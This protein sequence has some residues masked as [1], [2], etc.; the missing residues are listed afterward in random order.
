MILY[1]QS[2]LLFAEEYYRKDAA[3]P[4]L[5]WSVS[6]GQNRLLEETFAGC[7][8]PWDP[9][10]KALKSIQDGV[11]DPTVYALAD[12]PDELPLYELDLELGIAEALQPIAP[13][14]EDVEMLCNDAVADAVG[15]KLEE[16]HCNGDGT[17]YDEA[18]EAELVQEV[19]DQMKHEPALSAPQPFDSA[20]IDVGAF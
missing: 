9:S 20:S 19:L 3:L 5:V 17:S 1:V 15:A 4:F 11:V 13:T 7:L 18:H 10:P 8:A 14:N 6:N 16:A 12:E 2:E